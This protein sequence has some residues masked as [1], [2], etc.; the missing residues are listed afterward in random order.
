MNN[1][2]PDMTT[3]P[4]MV[5]TPT[6]MGD[7]NTTPTDMGMDMDG[8][9]CGVDEDFVTKRSE[10]AVAGLTIQSTNMYEDAGLGALWDVFKDKQMK[11]E[12]PAD[13]PNV[14]GTAECNTEVTLAAPI[15]ITGATVTGVGFT[16]GTFIQDSKS[17][18]AMF[19][20]KETFPVVG[21]KIVYPAAGDKLS[22]DVVGIKRY[23]C[24]T[25]EITKITNY[26]VDS[27]KNPV[28]VESITTQDITLEAHYN[29]MIKVGGT[30]SNPRE[31]GTRTDSGG[32]MYTARCF[33]L[34][35]GAEGAQKT[36]AVRTES[37]FACMDSAGTCATFVG[38][39]TS[40]P[41]IFGETPV[42]QLNAPNFKWLGLPY[43]DMSMTCPNGL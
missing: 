28:Y 34:S 12:F 35:Y 5:V 8:K 32:K 19:V 40:F 38:P 1:T 24:S 20:P 15:T 17:A 31:C 41:G 11:G 16:A 14:M 30:L 4:D 37:E 13:D 42:L 26:K 43:R 27:Q 25:P 23:G 29:K 3:T 21:G 10:L 18:M 33:D 9:A 36:I 2:T 39:V 6:D 22:F 7:M